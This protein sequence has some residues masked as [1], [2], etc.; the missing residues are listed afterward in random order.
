M[1][2]ALYSGRGDGLMTDSSFEANISLID[3]AKINQVL[4]IEELKLV[5]QNNW[6]DYDDTIE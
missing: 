6:K 3:L 1:K 4:D 2:Y 5:E